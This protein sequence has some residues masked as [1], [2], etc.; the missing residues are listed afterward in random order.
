MY[1]SAANFN[2]LSGH[3][4]NLNGCRIA[5]NKIIHMIQR[6]PK[7]SQGYQ[8]C[9]EKIDEIEFKNVNFKFN[10]PLFNNFNLTLKNGIIAFIGPSGNGKST[11]LNLLLKFY[12][13]MAG[14]IFVSNSISQQNLADI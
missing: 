11:L 2:P 8:E 9:L 12:E 3:F 10:Q 6:R 4:A 5:F 1:I 7:K 14:S 13:P